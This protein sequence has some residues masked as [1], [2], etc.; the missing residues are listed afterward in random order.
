MYLL[1][2]VFLFVVLGYILAN[3]DLTNKSLAAIRRARQSLRYSA[4]KIG[5]FFSSP[6]SHPRQ[7]SLAARFRKWAS[8]PGSKMLPADFRIWLASLSPEEAEIFTKSLQE[9]SKSLGFDL[10]TLVDGGLDQEPILR[11]VFVEAIIVYSPA[12]RRARQARQEAEAQSAANDK[13]ANSPDAE[14]DSE[15]LEKPTPAGDSAL[16]APKAA[17]A[18]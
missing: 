10:S 15:G 8:G 7:D 3:L 9:Y 11:Q 17:T 14:K 1:I 13:K 5:S 12:Y 16:E 4:K 2:F 6:G 18:V